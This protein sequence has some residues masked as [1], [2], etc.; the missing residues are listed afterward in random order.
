M[1][2]ESRQKIDKTTESLAFS[3]GEQGA[4]LEEM[5]ADEEFAADRARISALRVRCSALMK[6]L[7][8]IR[9]KNRQ[10][11]LGKK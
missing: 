2:V 3:I 4:S 6:E 10:G 8:N 5:Q 1:D 9:T 11:S 7:A